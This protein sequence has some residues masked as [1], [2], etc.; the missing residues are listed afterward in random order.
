MLEDGVRHVMFWL[1]MSR[2]SEHH[3]EPTVTTTWQENSFLRLDIPASVG[4]VIG[5]MVRATAITIPDPRAVRDDRRNSDLRTR[6][7]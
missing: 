6:P 1:Q 2:C 4:M 7:T 3:H 5:R